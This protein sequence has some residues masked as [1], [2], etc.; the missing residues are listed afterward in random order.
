MF[1]L[2]VREGIYLQIMEERHAEAVYSVVDGDREHLRPWLPWVDQSTS[3]EY[4]RQ[5]IH[6]SLEQFARNLGFSAAIRVG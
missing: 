5:F 2:S 6:G 3:S 1:Q 4:T